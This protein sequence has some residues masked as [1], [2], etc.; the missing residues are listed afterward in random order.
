[1]N[2]PGTVILVCRVVCRFRNL[3]ILHFHRVLAA[4]LADDARHRI[5]MARAVERAARIVDVDAFERG[6]EAVGVALAPD[7]AV[8]DD[9]EPGLLLRPDG[10]Q[11]RV[12][13]RFGEKA[14]G[15][16]HSSL[17]AHARRE[18][19]GELLAIDQPLGLRIAA[20]ERSGK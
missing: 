5:R 19:P 10:E 3:Q 16:R 7:L 17:R 15:T 9:V 8:G 12:V 20:D 6:G 13:L 1:M 11:R 14:S 4:D 2:G 18:T